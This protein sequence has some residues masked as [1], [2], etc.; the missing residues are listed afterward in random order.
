MDLP[1][2]QTGLDKEASSERIEIARLVWKDA[3]C[4][5]C[6]SQFALSTGVALLTSCCL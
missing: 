6:R 1:L 4:I 3:Q 2:G 5:S